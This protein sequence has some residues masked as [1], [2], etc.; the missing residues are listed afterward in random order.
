MRSADGPGDFFLLG[1]GYRAGGG[2]PD[3]GVD[4]VLFEEGEGGFVGTPEGEEFDPVFLVC[5]DFFF[6]CRDVFGAPIVG[7]AGDAEVFEHFGAL[8]GGALFGVEGDDA[9]GDEVF[10][11][12]VFG[13]RSGGFGGGRDRNRFEEEKGESEHAGELEI[14]R[15]HGGGG[16]V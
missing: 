12:E 14:F 13:D 3:L 11:A 4:F 5:E 15:D 9:P 1:T 7:A 10:G 2:L 8:G 6:E 16:D